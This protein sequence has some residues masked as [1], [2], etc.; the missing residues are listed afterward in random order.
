MRAVIHNRDD[1]PLKITSAR[2][3]QYERRVY[4]DCDAGISPALYYGDDKLNAPMYD[5]VRLFQSDARAEQLAVWR[6]RRPMPTIPGVPTTGRGRNVIRRFCGPRFSRRWPFWVESHCGR[7]KARQLE[8]NS[9]RI[10]GE[11]RR[12]FRDG[13]ATGT[14][15]WRCSWRHWD[16]PQL[17]SHK[18]TTASH[19]IR[20]RHRRPRRRPTI[21]L[22]ESGMPWTATMT[23]RP[24]AK[25][26]R[27]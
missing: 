1:A 24:S 27:P 23:L 18:R 7:S 25:V 19:L 9:K 12:N 20:P 21:A 14:V 2:L 16:F 11:T 17:R 4:F 22:S 3:Q 10:L 6:R 15:L 8:N 13:D 5:Y 26:I